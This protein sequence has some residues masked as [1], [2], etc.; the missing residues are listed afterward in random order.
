MSKFHTIKIAKINRLT[1]DSIVIEFDIPKNL[2]AK[3]DFIP[4]QHVIV[5]RDLD[6]EDIRRTYSF[7]SAP[8]EPHRIAIRKI[9]QGDFSSFANEKLKQGDELEISEP[10][11]G[12]NLNP[13]PGKN[14]VGIA[15]GSGITP[16]L[17]MLRASL[18]SGA[19]FHL[20]YGNRDRKHAMF[21]DELGALK[22]KYTSLLKMDLF[23]SRQPIDIPLL[24]G[25]IDEDKIKHI[26][27]TVWAKQEL[28]GFYLCGPAQMVASIKECL[29]SLGVGADKI[30][31]EL[32][33]AKKEQIAA[34]KPVIK[35]GAESAKITIINDGRKTDIAYKQEDGSILQ[36]AIN[37]GIDV[38]FACK[39]GV[40]A[41]CR[42]KVLQG[43]VDL[44]TIY[45]LEKEEIEAGFVLT[46]QSI[47][48]SKKLVISYDE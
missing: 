8:D 39:G 17:S 43:E 18:K 2:H 11:G 40:C 13:E 29:L 10:L 7:C 3:F 22:D 33:F 48:K 19:N 30:H 46:C 28:S 24:A 41:T 35:Q 37:A 38:S 1:P 20:L 25:R 36:A 31:T 16:I 14:Y 42:A 45:G 4:G 32:F 6:G 26:Y 12:F 5:R 15:A 47:P 9:K 21:F 23:F 34:T 44:G 27:K